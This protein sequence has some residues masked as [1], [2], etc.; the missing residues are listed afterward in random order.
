L[1][2]FLRSVRLVAVHK[3]FVNNG[4]GSCWTFAVEYLTGVGESAKANDPGISKR[5]DYKEALSPADFAVFAKLRDWRKE[6][7]AQEGVPVYT[8]FTNEQLARM[9]ENKVRTVADLKKIDG[10]GEARIK[11]Y[12]PAVLEVLRPSGTGDTAADGEEKSEE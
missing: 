8:V 12:G 2:R 10:V 4:E 9:S 7:A 1:N 11:K 5:V 6:A 3:D